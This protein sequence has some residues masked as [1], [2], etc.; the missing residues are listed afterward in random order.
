LDGDN[1]TGARVMVLIWDASIEDASKQIL[2]IMYLSDPTSSN[3]N[4][5]RNF[6]LMT[7]SGLAKSVSFQKEGNNNIG[8]SEML[9]DP[10]LPDPTV[11]PFGD[12]AIMYDDPNLVAQNG[13]SRIRQNVTVE[14]VV[15]AVST[16]RITAVV[17]C[18]GVRVPMHRILQRDS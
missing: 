8:Y 14:G 12:N 17:L 2:D 10:G 5:S 11:I 15:T 9:I 7:I 16:S 4:Y 13:G 6:V 1:P 18:L 3:P